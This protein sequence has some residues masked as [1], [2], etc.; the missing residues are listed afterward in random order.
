MTLKALLE[1]AG[2]DLPLLRYTQNTAPSRASSETQ[3]EAKEAHNA[4]HPDLV[5]EKGVVTGITY[6]KPGSRW[7]IA[8]VRFQD[9]VVW[10][11]GELLP[12][13][14]GLL[15]Q[16]GG[17]W[18][19]DPRWG[20][21]MRVRS[22]REVIPT[23]ETQLPEYLLA[24]RI[25]HMNEAL[26]R[27]ISNRWGIRC[28]QI[29]E[30]EP[31][32]LTEL[33]V[34]A[35]IA[36]RIHQ[37]W[38]KRLPSRSLLAAP[39][40]W[41][42]TSEQAHALFEY[43][44]GRTLSLLRRDPYSLL[45][46]AGVGFSAADQ[47]AER[48]GIQR[49]DPRRSRA[50][51]R[52]ILESAAVQDGDTALPVNELL[53]RTRSRKLQLTGD[54]ADQ[55]LQ[56]LED[57][58]ILTRTSDGHLIGLS[59]LVDA[60]REI[61]QQMMRLAQLKTEREVAAPPESLLPEQAQAVI[62]SQRNRFMILTG[63][64]G[65]GKTF[66]LRALLHSGWEKP[67]LAAPTGKAANRLSEMTGL[68]AFTLHRLLE[69]QPGKEA[70]RG[71]ER[72]IEADLLV[73]DEAAM[74]DVPLTQALMRAIDYE[75]TTLLLCG[76]ADQLP[77]VGPGNLLRNLINSK[78]FTVVQLT[79]IVRQDQHSQIIPNARRVLTGEPIVV[80]N[81]KYHDFKYFS[82]DASTQVLEQQNIAATLSEVF[83]NVLEHG[84]ESRDVQVLTPM[85]KGPVPGANALN[86]VLQKMM[87]PPSRTTPELRVAQ[88]MFRLGDRVM[89]LRNDYERGIFNGDTG[90]VVEISHQ[91]RE[92]KVLFDGRTVTYDE[93][94]LS[95]LE[96]AYAIS[97]HKS[98]GSEW[99]VVIVPLSL[100]HKQMLS[101]HLLYTSMTRAKKLLILVGCEKAVAYALHQTDEEGRLTTLPNW[102]TDG[103]TETR[104]C[105][106]VSIEKDGVVV[107]EA[108]TEAAH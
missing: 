56:E 36:R 3:R 8:R 1:R 102:I 106:D 105:S 38:K 55:A 67:V 27:D 25:P 99:P 62:E 91:D 89:Q 66:T 2:E 52:S 28:L 7:G 14:I 72:P 95:Q 76:D 31:Q 93:S 43:Y 77:P 74:L 68:P 60:E 17:T 13:R 87:N 37:N 51:L 108:A 47:V 49:L 33:G 30:E 54:A 15:Y 103:L 86:V 92:L 80:D 101:R 20:Q 21:G 48:V 81:F 65:T 23:D 75:K 88:A 73:I 6:Q 100:A 79:Q 70:I 44:G 35:D 71:E 98:Q 59:R 9:R 18:E 63:S 41:G 12:I 78:A 53:A 83:Q 82:V 26:C 34:P 50:A 61:A 40:V 45:N 90:V 96:L 85:K 11:K 64:P 84:F 29:L 57:E 46:R 69:Y 4:E 19:D 5:F 58:N 104:T 32:L 22:R 94:N 39:Q 107:T 10:A 42:M 24:L 97:I 16:F